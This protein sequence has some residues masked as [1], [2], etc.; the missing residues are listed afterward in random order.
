MLLVDP[1]NNA[2]RDGRQEMMFFPAEMVGTTNDSIKQVTLAEE[3]GGDWKINCDRDEMQMFV[4]ELKE[5]P[6]R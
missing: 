5:S 4:P 1:R 3:G 2:L 6:I